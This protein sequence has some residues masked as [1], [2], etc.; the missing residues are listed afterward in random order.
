MINYY[1]KNPGRF[2][3]Y[4]EQYFIHLKNEYTDCN[5]EFQ[6]D[7]VLEDFLKEKYDS[8]IFSKSYGVFY[9]ISVIVSMIISLFL[10][11]LILP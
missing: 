7:D 2:E 4:R 1:P 9:I 10:G 8:I 6:V 5:R 11:A 3:D